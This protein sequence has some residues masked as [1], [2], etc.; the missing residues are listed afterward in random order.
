MKW[1]DDQASLMKSGGTDREVNVMSGTQ[2]VASLSHDGFGPEKLIEVKSIFDF[3][4]NE[5][6]EAESE[7]TDKD[8]KQ[9]PQ[10]SAATLTLVEGFLMITGLML[11]NDQINRDDYRAVVVRTIERK[12]KAATGPG[13]FGSVSIYTC[14]SSKT[15]FWQYLS[16]LKLPLNDELNRF[17]FKFS[18]GLDYRGTMVVPNYSFD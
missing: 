9:E 2:F 5:Q 8:G 17:A 11:Q 16:T 18:P 4:V 1:I 13:F 10:L 6:K 15:S 12:K 3:I 7:W 14:Q